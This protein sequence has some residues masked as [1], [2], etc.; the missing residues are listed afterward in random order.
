MTNWRIL[1]SLPVI[2]IA[3]LLSSCAE[4]SFFTNDIGSAGSSA[5]PTVAA[6]MAH[7]KHE[8]WCAAN[9]QATLQHFEDTISS[10]NEN[11]GKKS[12]TFTLKDLFSQIRYAAS[13][14]FQL[15]VTKTMSA[16]PSAQYIDPTSAA[17]NFTLGVSGQLSDADHSNLT[18]YATVD[19]ARLTP[20][21]VKISGD[22]GLAKSPTPG[23]PCDEKLGLPRGDSQGI[24]GNLGLAAAIETQAIQQSMSD[25]GFFACKDSSHP[26]DTCVSPPSAL[27]ST[28]PYPGVFTVQRDF[29]IAGG[30]GVGPNWVLKY[31]K[32]P[33]AGTSATTPSSPSSSSKS[34]SGNGSGSPSNSG[35]GNSNVFGYNK[36]VKDQ[37]LITFA[38]LCVRN[39]GSD[40]PNPITGAYTYNPPLSAQM[41]SWAKYLA[42][43]EKVA[44]E[45]K[46]ALSGGPKPK[47]TVFG[48]T[49][50]VLNSALTRAI[51]G[52]ITNNP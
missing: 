9:S 22:P 47:E 52:N 5:G 17:T 41:P 12:D 45:A 37:I 27:S 43:C 26:D 50:Q 40:T 15:D 11:T 14:Q 23:E 20:P 7:V 4:F 3:A 29:T 21:I 6:F 44:K 38:P 32:G 42:P 13:I 18:T 16:N 31:F 46:N 24:G 19:T 34:S 39:K 33:N 28:D 36:Q 48:T 8:L 51:L 35:G 30:L 25:I 10:T 1:K 49:S 2:S